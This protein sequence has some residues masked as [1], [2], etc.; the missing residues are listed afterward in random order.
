MA[1]SGDGAQEELKRRRD[2]AARFRTQDTVAEYQPAVDLEEEQRRRARA[3]KF[4]VTYEP[5]DETGLAD[6]GAAHACTLCSLFTAT[7]VPL[8]S[9]LRTSTHVVLLPRAWHRLRWFCR[10]ISMMSVSAPHVAV[11]AAENSISS[12]ADQ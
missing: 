3:Q 2:R 12:C 4:G 8:S 11:H 7:G 1:L 9:R 6:A 10:G 5:T